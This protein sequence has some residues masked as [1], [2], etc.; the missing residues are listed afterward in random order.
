MLTNTIKITSKQK[1]EYSI[2]IVG[3]N[4]LSNQE[5][6]CI[7]GMSFHKRM[8]FIWLNIW[9]LSYLHHKYVCLKDGL[10]SINVWMNIIEYSLWLKTLKWI[11]GFI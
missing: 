11:A 9:T 2:E 4:T 7:F 3:L 6:R 5:R 1:I 8:R 10:K